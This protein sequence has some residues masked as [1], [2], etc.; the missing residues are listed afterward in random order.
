ML[1]STKLTTKLMEVIM[2]EAKEDS[3]ISNVRAKL[4]RQLADERWNY[5]QYNYLKN[6]RRGQVNSDWGKKYTQIMKEAPPNQEMLTIQDIP[7]MAISTV[8]M[9]VAKTSGA[10]KRKSLIEQLKS[11]DS[12]SSQQK[13][14]L[15][16]KKRNNMLFN[17]E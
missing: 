1:L 10:A 15:V 6:H 13:T 4:K 3:T 12:P 7:D 14:P 2:A 17:A 8:K 9:W 16:G 5:E 11:V